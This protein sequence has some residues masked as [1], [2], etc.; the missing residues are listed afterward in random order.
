M[1]HLRSNPPA[2]VAAFVWAAQMPAEQGVRLGGVCV[3]QLSVVQ[4]VRSRI[5]QAARPPAEGF[6]RQVD[7]RSETDSVIVDRGRCLQ[8]MLSLGPSSTVPESHS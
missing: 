5:V 6:A 3:A 8:W 2:Q 4:D 7:E 1:D